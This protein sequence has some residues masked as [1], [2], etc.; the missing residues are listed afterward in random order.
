[1]PTESFE[2]TV[3]VDNRSADYIEKILKSDKPIIIT[4]NKSFRR[5]SKK[6]LSVL[7]SEKKKN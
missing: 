6:E 5:L 7:F 4:S 2:K 1:M 3:V